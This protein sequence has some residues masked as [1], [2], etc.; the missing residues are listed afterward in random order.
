[1]VYARL[2]IMTTSVDSLFPFSCCA[3]VVVISFAQVATF[4]EKMAEVKLTG[5]WLL[6]ESKRLIRA[7]LKARG[8]A[9]EP[10]ATTAIEPPVRA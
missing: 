1:M 9:A 10:L 2:L 3:F 7:E 5:K 6:M 4:E 8:L